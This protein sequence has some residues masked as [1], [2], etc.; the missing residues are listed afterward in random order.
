MGDKERKQIFRTPNAALQTKDLNLVEAYFER[1]K[2]E[3]GHEGM[4]CV[5][6][7]GPGPAEKVR[8]K[9]EV[10]ST[11][12]GLEK[13]LGNHRGSLKKEGMITRPSKSRIISSKES[14]KEGVALIKQKEMTE[15]E[16]KVVHQQQ[17][18]RKGDP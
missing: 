8:R 14:K 18:M 12:R 13:A 11:P 17:K 1:K 16:G 10:R 15:T 2:N 9:R 7:R 6:N 4:I 5:T 3:R